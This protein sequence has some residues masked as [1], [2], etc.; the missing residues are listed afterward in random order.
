MAEAEADALR[1]PCAAPAPQLSRY[2]LHS[3][4]IKHHPFPP[5]SAVR[6]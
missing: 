1:E 5:P 2:M 6:S 3:A 4:S